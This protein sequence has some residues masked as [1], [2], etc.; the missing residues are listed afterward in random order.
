M[1]TDDAFE[2]SFSIPIE[3]KVSISMTPAA[4][5]DSV[6]FVAASVAVL[7]VDRVTT[8]CLVNVST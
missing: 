8:L 4:T 7:K 2:L 6:W 5:V 1:V 3:D